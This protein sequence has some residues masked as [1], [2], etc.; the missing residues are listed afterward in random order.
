MNPLAPVLSNSTLLFLASVAVASLLVAGAGLAIAQGIRRASLPL[1]HAVLASAL[2]AVVAG[3]VLLVVLAASG[4]G[5]LELSSHDS[6]S[7]LPPST[8]M[9][10]DQPLL[11]ASSVLDAA[12][13]PVAMPINVKSNAAA[14]PIA[15]AEILPAATNTSTFLPS[16]AWTWTWSDVGRW[17]IL[18]W[19][20]GILWNFLRLILGLL[21]L[22]AL[23]TSCRISTSEHIVELSQGIGSAMGLARAPAVYESPAVAAP[24]T[25]GLVRPCI[26]VPMEVA[27]QLTVEQ[28][29]GL[30][31]HEIGH[32]VRRDAYVGLLQRLALVVYWW[33]PLVQRVSAAISE[34][35]EQIC[36]DLATGSAARGESYASMLVELARQAACARPL[37][38]TIGMFDG[39]RREFSRRVE[40]LLDEGRSIVTALDGR[41]KVAATI[42]AAGL[43]ALT[44]LASIQF[45][46]IA[47]EA[48]TAKES[49]DAAP[50]P[51]GSEPP[52]VKWPKEL[53]GVVNDEVGRPIAGAKVRL[54]LEKIHEYK[55]GRWDETL[56]SRELTTGKDGTYRFD[57]AELPEMKHRPFCLKLSATADGYTES[58]T[59]NWYTRSD[60]KVD[61]H[62]MDLKLLP[63]RTVRGRVVDHNSEPVPGAV[64][65]A[66]ADYGLNSGG[67]AWGWDPRKTDEDGRFSIALP[68]DEKVPVELWVV[69]RD[70]APQRVPVPKKGDELSDI[71]LQPGGRVS[72]SVTRE[73]GSPI[74]GVVV[75]A[76][77]V[78]GGTLQNMGFSVHL[79]VKTDAG[80]RYQLPPID[81]IY[82]VYLSKSEET[83]DRIRDR[84]VVAD[85]PLPIVS[86]VRVAVSGHQ[87]AQV[88]FRTGS[89]L[90]VRGTVRWPDGKPVANCQVQ[91]SFMPPG[92][93]GGIWMDDT[94]TDAVGNY[95]VTL[96]KPIE[97]ISI[98]V[99]GAYDSKRVWHFGNPA[100][101]VQAKQKSLQFIVLGDL[102][103][104][105]NGIDWVLKAED[106]VEEMRSARPQ[107][108]DAATLELKK[109]E[110]RYNLRQ[111][112]LQD[113][114][115]QTNDLA[116]RSKLQLTRDPRVLLADDYLALEEK[117]RG[118]LAGLAALVKLN[119]MAASVGDLMPKLPEARRELCRRLAEHYITHPDLDV[120]FQSFSGGPQ[121]PSGLE[122]LERAVEVNPERTVQAAAI[123]QLAC[124]HADI[125][126]QVEVVPLM[127]EEAEAKQPRDEGRLIALRM[128]TDKL[129]GFDSAASREKAIQFAEN[130][131]KGYADLREPE[132]TFNGQGMFWRQ[133]GAVDQADG[134]PSYGELAEGL[135]F[136]LKQ[137]Q[138]GMPAPDIAT[139]KEGEREFATQYL[140]KVT[141]LMFDY[142]F[143][144]H[145]ERIMADWAKQQAGKPLDVL[146]VRTKLPGATDD[147]DKSA[148]APLRFVNEENGGPIATQWNI[149]RRPTFVVVD[150]NGVIRARNFP[151]VPFHLVSELLKVGAAETDR[152]F[153]P[154]TKVT[155]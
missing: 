152:V 52:A 41:T 19:A 117:Y 84:F 25:L 1:R 2:A 16:R 120:T 38:A 97:G 111:Q 49:A 65:K 28:L 59:W 131:E 147:G 103:A 92:F 135:L 69:S 139:E 115:A 128:A 119:Q 127:I 55:M 79:A 124:Y 31:R 132:R 63:G 121:L 64:V 48:E 70:W 60:T 42:I 74:N 130:L 68:T 11:P 149:R 18:L 80:G 153:V 85:G 71:R 26:V 5:F 116:K 8:L 138:V 23:W 126:D 24:L 95:T 15:V 17:L 99:I 101:H 27:S 77:S 67:R 35:R 46:S 91:A 29:Q 100:D 39:S 3:P 62:W 150:G 145:L 6:V 53:W 105:V 40:R 108:D 50:A 44:G 144:E 118:K 88:D 51:N 57:T 133:S 10:V 22:R 83:D 106:D 142:Y 43:V 102:T 13:E 81:G 61:E 21:R 54:D 89:T 94:R 146:V 82:R 136:D 75:V 96:P 114:L 155:R 104:D 109:L 33:N 122:L 9:S 20:A 4:V 32:I 87:D 93:G 151:E 137:L 78:D 112:E 98:N 125:A 45:E 7:T 56:W 123:Y 34:V 30:L 12:A 76:E 47:A 14:E 36:D 148:L 58:K 66:A 107:Q 113:A 37:P 154:D 141:V 140:G 73:D 129:K 86:P 143:D 134:K 72:G 90:T 110:R